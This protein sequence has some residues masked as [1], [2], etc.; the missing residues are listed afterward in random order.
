MLVSNN[1][2]RRRCRWARGSTPL[3]I[4]EGGGGEKWDGRGKTVPV[5]RKNNNKRE[6]NPG[7]N[8]LADTKNGKGKK[9]KRN[10]KKQ[11]IRGARRQA[12]KKKKNFA[13]NFRGGTKVVREGS[14]PEGTDPSVKAGAKV[15]RA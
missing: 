14:L 13:E 15:P 3:P 6:K 10:S 7:I 12:Q 9:Q 4:E 11:F 8:P 1:G 5:S 2:K